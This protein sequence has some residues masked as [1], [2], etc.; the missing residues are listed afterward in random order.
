MGVLGRANANCTNSLNI[1]MILWYACIFAPH[2]HTTHTI[3]TIYL[4]EIMM[5]FHGPALAFEPRLNQSPRSGLRRK[6]RSAN[7][8]CYKLSYTLTS[9]HMCWVYLWSILCAFC[10]LC[11]C[12]RRRSTIDSTTVKLKLYHHKY[13]YRRRH[14]VC[15]SW[16]ELSWVK[17]VC[18]IIDGWN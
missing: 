8:Q 15:I 10:R 5:A 13:H 2:T 1:V 16:V 3:C 4:F 17:W 9:Q 12:R 6:N 11:C 14:S 18:V 7:S